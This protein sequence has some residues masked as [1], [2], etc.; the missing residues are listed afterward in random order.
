VT[1]SAYGSALVIGSG[2]RICCAV[3]GSTLR[4]DTN[5]ARLITFIMD[6][7]V[8]LPLILRRVMLSK[9][10][11]ELIGRV[12]CGGG[13]FSMIVTVQND[14]LSLRKCPTD[15]PKISLTRVG[16]CGPLTGSPKEGR[17]IGGHMICINTCTVFRSQVIRW[18][19]DVLRAVTRFARGTAAVKL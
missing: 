13:S 4:Y 17:D 7:M 1:W 12:F 16:G 19:A 10:S 3:D 9:C 18:V 15:D 5:I 11:L 14:F 2:L 8:R 6:G